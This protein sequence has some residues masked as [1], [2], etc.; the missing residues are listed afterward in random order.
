MVELGLRRTLPM[1]LITLERLRLT[2]E[3]RVRLPLSAMGLTHVTPKK[4]E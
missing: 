3:V 1:I 2:W 4:N